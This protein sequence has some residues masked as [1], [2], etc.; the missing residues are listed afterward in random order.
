[1]RAR[2]GG[3]NPPFGSMK[4]RERAGPELHPIR[5]VG[6][7]SIRTVDSDDESSLG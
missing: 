4:M 3:R 2:Q 1:M 7:L 5:V 6:Y